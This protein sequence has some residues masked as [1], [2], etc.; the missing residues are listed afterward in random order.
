MRHADAHADGNSDGN[1]NS[2]SDSDGNADS[3]SYGNCDGNTYSHAQTYA[4][5]QAAADASSAGALIG[6]LK[7]GT[8]ERHLAS[9]PPQVDRLLLKTMASTPLEVQISGGKA[10]F[11]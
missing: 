8:R 9:S 11:V 4:D 7:A 2:D 6:T 5:A 3:H 10:G 1:G